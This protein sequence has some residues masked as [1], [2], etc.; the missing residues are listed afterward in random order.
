[1]E[2]IILKTGEEALVDEE[3][4]GYLDQFKWSAS[5]SGKKIYACTNIKDKAGKSRKKYM[6]RMIV[7]PNPG[8]QVDH[9][10]GNS[11]DN[12]RCNLRLCD[13][14]QNQHNRSKNDGTKF[15]GVRKVGD[16]YRMTISK[17][18]KT[19]EEAALVYNLL[20]KKLFGE[21]AYQNEV[22]DE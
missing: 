18:F 5:P 4:C 17:T 15:K 14:Y 21:F 2:K 7:N 9:I 12:R 1:M 13:N 10:N 22:K 3:D 11:L 19:A 6:H 8:Q 20:A 16:S